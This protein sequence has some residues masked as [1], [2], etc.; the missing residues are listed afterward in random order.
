MVIVDYRNT[1]NLACCTHND[2]TCAIHPATGRARLAPRTEMGAVAVYLSA[3]PRCGP[4][5][6]VADAML[7]G[8]LPSWKL[9]I[10]S[11]KQD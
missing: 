4:I 8:R 2:F 5:V 9:E 6:S 3:Q 11:L 7:S 10:N 1:S